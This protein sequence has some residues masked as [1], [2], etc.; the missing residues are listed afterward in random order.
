MAQTAQI[1]H[2]NKT[3]NSKPFE[4]LIEKYLNL[5]LVGV[6]FCSLCRNGICRSKLRAE[7][8]WLSAQLGHSP[9]MVQPSFLFQSV[10]DTV[11][12]YSYSHL[13]AHGLC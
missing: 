8:L 9:T 4:N 2:T 6:V 7:P 3:Y 5:V 11:E 13:A 1:E 12:S 10:L